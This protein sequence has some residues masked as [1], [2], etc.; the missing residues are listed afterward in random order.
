MKLPRLLLPCLLAVPPAIAVEKPSFDC[1]K[2][3]AGSVAELICRDKALIRL[4]RSLAQAYAQA[5]RKA[6]TQRPNQ[7]PSEQRG[8]ISG[9]DECWKS[10]DKAA[11]VR[12]AYERRIVELQAHYRLVEAIGPVRYACD[13]DVRNEVTATFFATDPPSLIAERGDASALMLGER[14][15]S[16]ARYVGRNESLWEHQGEAT[17]VWG[18]GAKPMG[19]VRER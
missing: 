3:R 7:L 8:W 14:S 16:G 17:I 1:R 12:T 5:S 2:V 11:C 4:D 9:R 15:G 18:Y 6:A 13:G 10:D 19:C